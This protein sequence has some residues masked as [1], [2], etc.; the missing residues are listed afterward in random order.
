MNIVNGNTK[1]EDFLSMLS[2]KDPA[3]GGGGASAAVAAVGA[4]LGHMVGSL[5]EGKKKYIDV[6]DDIERMNKQAKGLINELVGLVQKDAE[7]FIPL[8]QAYGLPN[9]TE[10]EQRIK[11]EV[12]ERELNNACSVPLE[13]MDKCSQAINLCIEYAKKGS[14]LA[15]SD[16]AAGI[17]IC[18]AA[19]K[20]ASLNVY[21]NTKLMKNRERAEELNEKVD[22]FYSDCVVNAE[23]EFEKI[24]K[25]LI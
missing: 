22:R 15:V 9:N 25:S 1:I 19:L 8:S 20:A 10:E 23:E 4:A 2:S 11:N 6:R 14:R 17:I 18:E 13:I 3:P 21:I 5:T 16:A 7:C 24:R 12:L